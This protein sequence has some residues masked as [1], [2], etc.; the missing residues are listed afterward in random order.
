MTAEMRRTAAAVGFG[1]VLAG[2]FLYGAQLRAASRGARLSASQVAAAPETLIGQAAAREADDTGFS[3]DDTFREVL[4]RVREEYYES[5]QDEKKMASGAVRTM[6]ASLD[7]PRTRYYDAAQRKQL[8]GQL[9]GVY[10][11][12]GASLAVIK[13]KKG[14]VEQ[15]RLR[16][17]SPATGGPADRAGVRP[18]D[19]ITEIDGHWVI[20][21]DPR[22]DI[23]RSVFSDLKE[24]EKKQV[25]NDATQKLKDGISLSKALDALQ[26]NAAQAT[27]I[28]VERPGVAKP[29][30][31]TVATGTAGTV[32]A[33]FRQL[34][35][36]VGYLRITQFTDASLPEVKRAVASPSK[37]L[38]VDLRDNAGGPVV[39]GTTGVLRA[40]L[41]VAGTLTTG[42]AIGSVKRASG[43]VDDLAVAKSTGVKQRL[44]VIV[45][46]GTA[47]IAEVVA[48]ALREKAHAC[49]VGS[50]TAGDST[51]Q[52]LFYLHDGGAM[53]VTS[54]SLRTSQGLDFTGT[55]LKPDVPVATG[56]PRADRDAAVERAVVTL[57]KA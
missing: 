10:S 8:D 43:R 47:N 52:K 55:G 48:A 34:S 9:R 49:V 16:V 26:T 6:L 11:G 44:A 46:N 21:Y 54:G 7:D 19:F 51:Y 56:G 1:L 39:G 53:T 37:S 50:R 31:L 35:P 57:A 5:K 23:D 15:R 3:P 20:A 33:E 36:S 29:L 40:A 14:L 24:R 30:K 28:T 17:V 32:P 45:N 13:H 25:W 41:G 18:G 2:A 4:E 22:L 27:T 38:I 42:G 12:I